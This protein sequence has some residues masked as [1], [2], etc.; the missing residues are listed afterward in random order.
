MTTTTYERHIQT[1]ASHGAFI[2]AD[3]GAFR[4]PITM[5]F[6]RNAIAACTDLNCESATYDMVLP[7]IGSGFQI[8]IWRS[9]RVDSGK[10]ETIARIFD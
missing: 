9:G 4:M 7:G 2:T 3:N 6:Y 1:L 5:D 10:T 8:V